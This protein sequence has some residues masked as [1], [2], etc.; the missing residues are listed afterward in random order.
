MIVE[1]IKYMKYIKKGIYLKEM[2]A[3]DCLY[4]RCYVTYFLILKLKHTSILKIG[5]CSS[6]IKKREFDLSQKRWDA[7]FDYPN[8]G[9]RRWA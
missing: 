2:A 1:D 9:M 3:V 8:L 4:D 5:S 6:M 7:T